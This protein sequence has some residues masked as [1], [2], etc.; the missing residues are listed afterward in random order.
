M[1]RIHTCNLG[2]NGSD[3]DGFVGYCS[4]KD[5]FLSLSAAPFHLLPGLNKHIPI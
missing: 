2:Y 1:Q 5:T 3:F 4:S